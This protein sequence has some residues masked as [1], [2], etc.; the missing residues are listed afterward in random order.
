MQ[1]NTAKAPC[2]VVCKVNTYLTF[3]SDEEQV[4]PPYVG[5]NACVCR[6]ITENSNSAA[7]GKLVIFVVQ[8]LWEERTPRKYVFD[9]TSVGQLSL[10]WTYNSV[11]VEIKF[12]LECKLHFLSAQLMLRQMHLTKVVESIEAKY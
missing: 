5:R 6:I 12:H 4:E 8:V 2:K 1:Y 9:V 7:F 3:W 11:K 10:P